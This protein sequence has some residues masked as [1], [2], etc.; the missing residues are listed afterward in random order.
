MKNKV[1]NRV[2]LLLLLFSFKQ[3]IAQVEYIVTV[4]PTTGVHTKID[5][6]QGV[7]WITLFN[8][9]TFDKING[10]FIFRGGDAGS[11]WALYTIDVT[12]GN[13]IY[14]PPFPVLVN[15]ADN[16]IELEFDNSSGML[17]ALHWDATLQKE[18]LISIDQVTGSY[19]KIDSIPGVKWIAGWNYST[20][21]HVNGRYIFRG[22]DAAMNWALYSIDVSTGSII[23]N[24]T[25]PQ[26]NVPDVITGLEYDNSSGNL[27]GLLWDDS[28][29]TEFFITV[30]QT[31]GIH[32]ILSSIPGVNQIKHSST[33]IDELNGRYIFEGADPVSGWKLY[34]I[35]LTNGNVLFD[36]S[37]P[38]GLTPPENV[39]ELDF[40][41]STGV[42]YALHWSINTNSG[43]NDVI[44]ESFL[45]YPNPIKEKARIRFNRI[46]SK[47][48]IE[49]YNSKGEIV[50]ELH[51]E[52]TKLLEFDRGNLKAGIH[53]VRIVN[54]ANNV[55]RKII[56]E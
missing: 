39:I 51:G 2:L 10:R 48:D 11:N 5:S 40:D 17:Y 35:D 16:I 20:Y 38:V 12:T 3:G 33:S 24:P 14:N 36:P 18:F 7:K 49:I 50:K 1:L 43:I 52:N 31:T 42:L 47:V 27:Y 56:I 41:D 44:N 29:Q 37:F 32:T 25:F 53:F 13:I 9:S 34:S 23:S 19:T 46:Q 30:D 54:D 28:L 21:D 4:D 6:I 15:S 22:A 45:V 26:V 8:Y 55:V